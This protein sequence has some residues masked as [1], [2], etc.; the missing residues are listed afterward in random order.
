MTP[1]KPD[2]CP[3]CGG[4]NITNSGKREFY[5][6]GAD[7][8]KDGPS[9]IIYAFRCDCGHSWGVEVKTPPEPAR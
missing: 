7:R 4:S 1:P 2:A 3:R 5:S 6:L 8:K 9:S